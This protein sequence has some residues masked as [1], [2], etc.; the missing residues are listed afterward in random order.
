[1]KDQDQERVELEKQTP[2]E[3]LISFQL[4]FLTKVNYSNFKFLLDVLG[5]HHSLR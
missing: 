4:L 5:F 3:V 2:E 1:M